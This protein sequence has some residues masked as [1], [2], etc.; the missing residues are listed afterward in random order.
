[1]GYREGAGRG[2]VGA[3]PV[4]WV[5]VAAAMLLVALGSAAQMRAE[6]RLRPLDHH[7]VV[8]NGGTVG[9]AFSISDGVAVT[10]RHVV[11]GLR[12]GESV[13]LLASG[14]SGASVEGRLIA[15]SPLMDLAVVQIPSGF[16]PT[17]PTEDAP[18]RA[19]LAVTA[20]GIDASD[21]RAGARF[22]ADGTVL[23]PHRRIAA[24]G[25]GLIARIPRARPGF[26]GGPLFDRAG[27]FAGM[28]TAI[29]PPEGA[30]EGAAGRSNWHGQ[31][32]VDAFALRAAEVRAEVRRLLTASGR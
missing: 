28:V 16:L 26:S 24:F 1:M 15:V 5:A 32:A 22:E 30:I 21:G 4:R 12:R 3:C 17:V 6:A 13:V 19:G 14:G 11:A 9:S 25:P 31:P 20:V 18:E 2:A 7:A 29:R 27:R 8:F 10:N 23:D